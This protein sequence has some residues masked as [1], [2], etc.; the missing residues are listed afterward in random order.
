[1]P[2]RRRF[3]GLPADVATGGG[4]AAEEVVAVVA[5]RCALRCGLFG[6]IV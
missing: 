1:M 4:I 5:T 2:G 3:Q 6:G